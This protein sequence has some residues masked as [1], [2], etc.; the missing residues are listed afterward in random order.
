[1]FTKIK[2]QAKVFPD[3]RRNANDANQKIE[4]KKM[5]N[6]NNDWTWE[7]E[8]N[9]LIEETEISYEDLKEEA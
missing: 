5:K 3:R 8:T 9:H 7:D 6:Q 1:L 4:T 2:T